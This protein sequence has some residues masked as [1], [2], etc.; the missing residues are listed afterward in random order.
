MRKPQSVQALTGFGRTRLSKTFFMRDFLYS[1]IATIHGLSNLPDDPDLAIAAG[2][3]LCHE[4]L[5]PLQ[6]VFGRLAVRSSYR[7]AEVNGFGCAQQ[8]AGKAGYN[9]AANHK[10]L[11][12]HI[13]DRRDADGCMGAMACIVVPTFWNRFQAPGDWQRLAWWI[14]D[15][16]PY[17]QM[18]FF[19]RYFAFNLGWHERPVRRIDSFVA[20]KGCLT[21]PGMANHR[22][23][24]E[25]AWRGIL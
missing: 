23:S 10:D 9:C 2:T 14:H 18:Q 25:A 15:H 19:P 13:W 20:P 16:L 1:D 7:S 12:G 24:H 22:G 8:R 3:R 11:G 5:E 17:S 4:L 6:D 21:K